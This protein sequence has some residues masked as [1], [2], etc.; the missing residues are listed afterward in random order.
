[1]ATRSRRPDRAIPAIMAL[2]SLAAQA[3]TPCVPTPKPAAMMYCYVPVV[4]FAPRIVQMFSTGKPQIIQGPQRMRV[5]A[6]WTREDAQ[7]ELA[8]YLAQAPPDTT[9]YVHTAMLGASSW[10]D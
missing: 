7:C 3:Q 2:A 6:F 5:G 9:G 10:C 4:T 1:M 8:A